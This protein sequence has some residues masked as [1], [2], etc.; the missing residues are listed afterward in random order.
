MPSWSVLDHN[1]SKARVNQNNLFIKS[2]HSNSSQLINHQ[3]SKNPFNQFHQWPLILVTGATGYIG[4]HVVFELLSQAR[5]GVI[6]VDNLSNSSHESLKRAYNLASQAGPCPPLYFHQVDICDRPKLFSILKRYKKIDGRSAIHHVIHFAALKS[7]NGSRLDP[8][9]YYFTNLVGTTRLLEVMESIG[10]R[11]IVFS[12]SAVVYGMGPHADHQTRTN[13]LSESHCHVRIGQ[14][15]SERRNNYKRLTNPY[16]KTKLMCE[17]WIHGLCNS[18]GFQ[19]IILR[20]TNPSGNHPSGII[21]DS[22]NQ[23]ENLMPIAAQVL[24]GIRDQILIY[25]NDYPTYDG[26]GVRDFIHVQDLAKGHL[27]ALNGLESLPTGSNSYPANCRTYNLGTGKGAS[28]ME[29]INALI[30]VSGQVIKTR[31]APRR[32]GDLAVVI[33]NPS[34]AERELGWRAEKDIIEMAQDLWTFCIKNPHGLNSPKSDNKPHAVHR[35]VNE[36]PNK[37]PEIIGP[38]YLVTILP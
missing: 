19:A 21:G 4:S 10:V 8:A 23:P 34:K 11:S 2:S 6:A 1:L 27:A 15:E 22:P 32:P 33:C 20:Y 3:S 31:V 36:W 13:L 16:G 12:S 29:V 25:G 9:K 14:S 28:V 17:E 26:T 7:V 38:S 5:V 24:Q 37:Q 35:S 18:K 30:K